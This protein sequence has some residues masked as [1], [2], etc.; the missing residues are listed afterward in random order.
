MGCH[1]G[2]PGY[3]AAEVGAACHTGGT[4][5]AA[6]PGYPTAEV[7]APCHTG[8]TCAAASPM[9][10]EMYP[11]MM[12]NG[13]AYPDGMNGIVGQSLPQL[14]LAAAHA[15]PPIP[16][17]QQ[18]QQFHPFLQQTIPQWGCRRRCGR[19]GPVKI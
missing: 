14:P 16:Q 1:T 15:W 6:S 9:Y 18:H 13:V 8:G 2:G 12:Q 11:A 17:Q 19:G 7:G 5:A 4:C 10:P 3:P